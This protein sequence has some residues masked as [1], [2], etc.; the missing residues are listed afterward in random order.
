M[1][2]EDK[3]YCQV[4][5]KQ[6]SRDMNVIDHDLGVAKINFSVLT[7]ASWRFRLKFCRVCSCACRSCTS[8]QLKV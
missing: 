1:Y 7:T 6:V 4:Y 8:E 3:P 5:S 2:I